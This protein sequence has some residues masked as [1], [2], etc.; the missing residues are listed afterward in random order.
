M[1][2]PAKTASSDLA[3]ELTAHAVASIETADHFSFPFPHIVFRNFFPAGFYREL[4][5]SVPGEGYDPI[6]DTGTRLALRL[7]GENLEKIEPA[8][9]PAWAAVSTMLTSDRVERAI[10]NRLRDGLEIRARGDKVPGADD[11]QLVAKPVVYRDRDGYRIKPH[12]DTRKKV[13]TMQL[14][15]PADTSQEALGTTLYRASL[16]GLFHVGSYCLEPVKTIPFLP[17]VGYA[18]V[19]LKAYHSLTR[20]SWHGRPPIKTDQPRISILNTFYMNEHVGF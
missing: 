19:V 9:R 13:V 17:N 1:E 18:F 4:V 20:M 16:K 3:D 2:A 5:R 10:R 14:Y 12:P 11:L 15:C 8:L 6:T 7:Y